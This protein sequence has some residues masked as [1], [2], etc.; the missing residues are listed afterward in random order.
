MKTKI[1]LKSP[2]D[3]EEYRRKE[4]ERKQKNRLKKLGEMTEEEKKAYWKKESDRTTRKRKESLQ[5]PVKKEAYLHS[6]RE[7]K[8]KKNV[9]PNVMEAEPSTPSFKS[10]QS[11]GKAMSRVSNALPSSPRKQKEVISGLAQRIGLQLKEKMERQINQPSSELQD[12]IKKFYYREDIVYTMPGKDD[13]MTVKHPVFG[14]QRLRVHYLNMYLREA[15]AVFQ[16]LEPDHASNCSFAYFAKQRP[17]NVKLV[18]ETPKDQCQC[19][20]HEN[21]KLKMS[22]LG[23]KYDTQLWEKLLCETQPNSNC[24]FNQ[25][26]ECKNGRKIPSLV[27]KELNDLVEYSQWE[28]VMVKKKNKGTKVE[29]KLKNTEDKEVLKKGTKG[30]KSEENK[31]E[32]KEDMIKVLEKRARNVEVNIVLEEAIEGY[33]EMTKHVNTKRIQAAE[34][35]KDKEDQDTRTLQVDYAMAYQCEEQ[36]EVQGKLFTRPSVNLFT[37]ALTTKGITKTFCIATDYQN[38]DKYANYVFLKHLY[39]EEFP[40]EPDLKEVIWSD[41]PSGEFKNRYTVSTLKELS[42]EFDKEFDWKFSARGHGKGVVDGVGGNVKSVVRKRIAAKNPIIRVCNAKTFV[43]IASKYCKETNVIHIDE[44]EIIKFAQGKPFTSVMAV[45]G[46][47]LIHHIAV[48][49]GVVHKWINSLLADVNH[50]GHQENKSPE[51]NQ[52]KASV[53]ILVKKGFLQIC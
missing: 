24:W 45:P 39:G 3:I 21:F 31:K 8:R 10:K 29:A 33:P 12:A 35:Q 34:F 48:K 30:I 15:H 20:L 4:R 42:D 11:L 23:I 43:E 25:C 19:I 32:D 26:E 53:L 47:S 2:K 6:E 52:F 36:D 49:D 9:T 51:V 46:I 22:A 13:L 28:F 27:K 7:R 14:K 1:A 40:E 38:K 16:A 18:G 50:D 44:E 5:D 37:A 17:K 41:G